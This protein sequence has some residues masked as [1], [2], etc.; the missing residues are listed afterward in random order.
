M[1]LAINSAPY[2]SYN[3]RQVFSRGAIWPK[4][5]QLGLNGLAIGGYHLVH[6]MFNAF[7]ALKDLDLDNIELLD[8]SWKGVIEGLRLMTGLTMF[9]LDPGVADS[10]LGNINSALTTE[11]DYDRSSDELMD[12]LE[13]YVISGGNHPCLAQD[14][15][16]KEAIQFLQDTYAAA[17]GERGGWSDCQ[18]AMRQIYG[19]I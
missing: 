9:F 16:P 10:L 11:E 3:Y 14:S 5:T 18:A 12:D 19:A 4:L 17:K 8:G 15:A 2:G 1:N 6:L 13:Q 7:P